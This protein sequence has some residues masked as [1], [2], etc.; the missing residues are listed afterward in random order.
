M[1]ARSKQNTSKRIRWAARILTMSAVLPF[2]LSGIMKVVSA[3]MAV[4]AL[5]QAEIPQEVI[6]AWQY[7]A[8]L[9]HPLSNPAN[10]DPRNSPGFGSPNARY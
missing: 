3:P 4:Q 1:S 10:H 8:V 7:R 6:F 9:P 2:A 5:T